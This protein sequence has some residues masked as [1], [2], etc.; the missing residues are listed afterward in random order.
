MNTTDAVE[1]LGLSG[2]VDQATVKA[3]YRRLARHHHPDRGGDVAR[4]QRIQQAYEVLVDT[5]PGPSPRPEPQQRSASVADRWWDSSSRWFEGEVDVDAVDWSRKVPSLG[6][7]RVDRDLLA[8]MLVAGG[9]VAAVTLR[10]R[11]PGSW[12][13]RFIDWLQPDLLA[14]V[15]IAPAD[16]QGIAGHDV[17]V[18]ATF[19]T[20]KARRLV[21]D[22]K[23]PSGWAKHR[24][25]ATVTVRRSLHP[26]TQRQATAVRVADEVDALLA[27]MA[28]PLDDWFVVRG[29]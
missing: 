13:H 16:A 15:R 6:S 2:R 14:D 10:S 28:W 9:P 8:T 4:F 19:R 27:S 25:S 29:R 7:F 21:G 24:G 3:A 18:S 11:A 23:L 1:V 22:A 26:A 5:L 12:S 20:I 17:T